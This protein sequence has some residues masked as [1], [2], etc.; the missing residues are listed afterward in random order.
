MQAYAQAKSRI[1]G[2]TGL[3]VLNRDD[4]GVMTMLPQPVRA[5]LQRPVER[6]HTTF[7]Y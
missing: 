7:G 3:M 1:F 6:P 4:A 5:K 2:S